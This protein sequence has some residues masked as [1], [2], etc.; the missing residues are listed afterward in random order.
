MTKYFE[1]IKRDGP[2][3]LGKLLLED[4][5]FTP[6][7]LSQNDFISIGSIFGYASVDEAIKKAESLKGQRKLAVKPYV[8]E[9]INFRSSVKLPE[10]EIDGPKGIVVNSAS[11]EELERADIYILGSI[12]MRNPRDFVNA[13]INIRNRIPSD[14]ALYAPAL[15]RPSNLAYLIYL[16]IDLVDAIRME[17]DACFGRYHTRDGIFSV[18]EFMELPCRCQFCTELANHIDLENEIELLKGHNILKLTEEMA[19]TRH[20]IR[21]ERIREYVERLVRVT[22]ELTASLRFLDQENKYLEARTPQYRKSIFYA[23]TAE[24]LKRVE[25]KRFADRVLN[26]YRPPQS[27]VLLL[28]PCSAHKPYSTS[29]SHRLFAEAMGPWRKFLHEVILT[30]PLALVPRELE[31]IYPAASYDVPVT[32]HWDLEERD[33][34]LSCLDAYLKKNRYLRIVAHI[35]GELQEI[36]EH[37]GIDAVFTS[38]GIDSAA[39]ARL[40]EAIREACYG[41]AR[42]ENFSLQRFRAVSDYYFGSKA[43]DALLAGEVKIRGKEVQ[44]ANDKTLAIM[45][46][47][48]TMA[49]SLEGARRLEKSGDY[50]VTIGDFLP[51]GSLLAPGVVKADE[52]IRPGDELIIRG[53]RAF[54]VGRAK[55]SGWEM[56]SSNKGIAAEIRQIEAL[57]SIS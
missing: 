25:I 51:R 17:V 24:S 53:E 8:P 20:L 22:P 23:N 3:R 31:G 38:G 27:D 30:S 5:I 7:L 35:E 18:N 10:I 16:G 33:W 56:V 11:S 44:D 47:N 42:L 34:L 26:R 12:P 45:T 39:I 50:I 6:G 54:G 14:T 40:S 52:Q 55:M 41:V 32:G 4:E 29:R 48:G 21:S 13:I 46:P 57:K 1:V 37:H 43:S 28:L 15:A 2:A 36:I 49:L 19:I 9:F